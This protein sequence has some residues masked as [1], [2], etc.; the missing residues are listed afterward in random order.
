MH[1]QIFVINTGKGFDRHLFGLK[2]LVEE[3]GGRVPELFTDPA[4]QKLN[5]IILSTSTVSSPA[6][7]IGG[8]AP[9]TPDGFGVGEFSHHSMSTIFTQVISRTVE[10]FNVSQHRIRNSKGLWEM[11]KGR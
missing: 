8:F 10:Q 9:V 2:T 6:I 1:V 11:D 7:L 3:E 5:H 4:Y